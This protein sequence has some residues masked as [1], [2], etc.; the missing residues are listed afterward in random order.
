[1]DLWRAEGTGP[2][3][4]VILRAIYSDQDPDELD[5][6]KGYFGIHDDAEVY[7][8]D[9]PAGLKKYL[10]GYRKIER[11]WE[12][13]VHSQRGLPYE[14]CPDRSFLKWIDIRCCVVETVV[15]GH[16]AQQVVQ[17]RMGLPILD[18]ERQIGETVKALSLETCWAIVSE[19]VDRA[20][21]LKQKE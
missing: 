15:W 21:K 13:W 3:Y 4:S 6:L 20:V 11:E 10:P 7:I 18:Q 9:L 16:P 1:M 19:V 12:L 14:E 8:S 5:V 2:A 17:D